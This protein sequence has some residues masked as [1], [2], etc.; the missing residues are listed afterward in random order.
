MDSS[1]ETLLALCCPGLVTGSG[2]PPGLRNPGLMED[3]CQRALRH[4]LAPLVADRLRT[5]DLLDLVPSPVR[6][7]LESSYI[8]TF[9][10][11]QACL[12]ELGRLG[13]IFRKLDLEFLILKGMALTATVY[14]DPGLRPMDD[15]DILVAPDQWDQ[16]VSTLEDSGFRRLSIPES[17]LAGRLKEREIRTMATYRK[18]VLVVDLHSRIGK[19]GEPMLSFDL[20]N[21]GARTRTLES[22]ALVCPAPE[23]MLLHLLLHLDKHMHRGL[24]RLSNLVDILRFVSD[25]DTSVDWE[26]F[27]DLCR[28]TGSE[29][30]CAGWLHV[31][32][33]RFRRP[34]PAVFPEHTPRQNTETNLERWL[35]RAD[36]PELELIPPW[37]RSTYRM[38]RGPGEKV[39]FTLSVLFPSFAY[40]RYAYGIRSRLALVWFHPY[41]IIDRGIRY[42]GAKRR[43]RRERKTH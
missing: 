2:S 19:T 41:R 10:K 34:V 33:H 37:R 24:A 4:G 29:S 31:L 35:E 15:V 21:T 43:T 6:Q 1:V 11:N 3:V 14:R 20:M 32:R 42:L 40:M 22:L 27:R 38:A 7:D 36:R 5:L 30:L 9:A 17:P 39:R 28:H 18:G 12:L 25:P 8:E 16:A 23:P 26:G 13:E